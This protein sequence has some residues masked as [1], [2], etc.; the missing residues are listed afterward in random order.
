[1]RYDC[2][3]W[4]RPVRWYLCVRL[5]LVVIL[6]EATNGAL[7]EVQVNIQSATFMLDI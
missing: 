6:V 1:V 2:I 4:H 5:L 7:Q 3:R